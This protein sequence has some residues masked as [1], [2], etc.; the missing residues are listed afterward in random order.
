METKQPVLIAAG[1]GAGGGGVLQILL[2]QFFAELGLRPGLANATAAL[3]A[4]VVPVIAGW[5]AR[6]RVVTVEKANRQ[7]SAAFETH[8]SS[9]SELLEDLK[10]KKG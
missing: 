10:L 2:F 3:I 6:R 4:F 9:P 8:P 5:I 7:I 1:I